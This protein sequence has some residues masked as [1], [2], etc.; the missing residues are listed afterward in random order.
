MDYGAQATERMAADVAG[1]LDTVAFEPDNWA[2][3]AKAISSNFPG[4]FSAIHNIDLREAR[5][6]FGVQADIDPDFLASYESHFFSINPWVPEWS[7]T[8]SGKV[9]VASRHSPASNFA[10]TEF[11]ND[12]LLP[13]DRVAATGMRLDIVGQNML[14]IVIH[15]PISLASVYDDA[16]ALLLSRIR[17]SL[18][19]TI[20]IASQ[21]SPRIESHVASTALVNRTG[22][23]ALVVDSAMRLRDA[24]GAAL[25]AFEKAFPLRCTQDHVAVVDRST[26][27]WLQKM[28][29]KLAAGIPM[30]ESREYFAAAG[31]LFRIALCRLPPTASLLGPAACSGQ[32]FLVVIRNLTATPVGADL[33]PLTNQFQLT[34]AEAA[35]AQHLLE[36]A[37]LKE[38]AER[39]KITQGTAR[40]R[41]KV[42]FNKTDTH[43]QSELIA[44]LQRLV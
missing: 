6:N 38:A 21:L 42:I 35:L 1:I 30:E 31:V 3:A 19:R 23:I 27:Q 10:S 7:S 43:R 16:T 11:Y 9:L 26:H 44:L 36:G 32:L 5:L 20:D 29:C 2:L 14:H 24:N 17:G 41:L 34:R 13:Q 39:L 37:S 33:S 15:Y 25:S 4:S 8:P 40:Q 18:R 12:W 28:V 22:E